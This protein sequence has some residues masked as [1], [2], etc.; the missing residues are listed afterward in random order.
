MYRFML[1][2]HQVYYILEPI[3][4]FKLKS[5]GA[6]YLSENM[7]SLEGRFVWNKIRMSIRKY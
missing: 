3:R 2:Y 1:E 7:L 6:V 4:I 5:T